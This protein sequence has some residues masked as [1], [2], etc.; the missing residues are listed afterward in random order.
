MVGVENAEEVMLKNHEVA[1]KDKVKKV[2]FISILRAEH[3]N[4]GYKYS[5][6]FI[7]FLRVVAKWHHVRV[8]VAQLREMM[9]DLLL[10]PLLPWIQDS[11]SS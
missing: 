9:P 11:Y 7:E 8:V 6:F 3:K 10:N 2:K 5:W 4:R 1:M